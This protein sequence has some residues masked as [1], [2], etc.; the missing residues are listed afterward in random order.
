MT[1]IDIWTKWESQTVNELFPLRRFLGRS[2][3]SVVFL[4]DCEARNISQAAIKLVPADPAMAE[5]HLSRWKRIAALSHPH[6]VRVFDSGRCTLG[7]HPF[8][9]IVM[10]YA[11]QS[12]AQILQHRALTLEEVREL[13]VPTLGCI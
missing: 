9:F 2:D 6:L 8:L 12:L 4:T 13:L 3:H 5:T 10:E 7:G 11:E 1:E